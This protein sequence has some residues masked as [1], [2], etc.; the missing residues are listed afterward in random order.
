V[1]ERATSSNEKRSRTIWK[2]CEVG[3]G[4]NGDCGE[5]KRL[6]EF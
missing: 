3:G 6:A 2:V 5:R 1:T 4:W